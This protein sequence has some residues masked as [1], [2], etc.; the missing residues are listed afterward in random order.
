MTRS[1]TFGF[2]ALF[3][4]A[5]LSSS[6]LVA[7]DPHDAS[8]DDS[9]ND[10]TDGRPSTKGQSPAQSTDPQPAPAPASGAPT[11]AVDHGAPSTIFPAFA[12]RPPQVVNKGGAVAA[13]P[14]L[15]TVTW[16]NDA[17]ADT[18]EALADAIGQSNYWSQIVSQYGV[19]KAT[20]D[21]LDH[22]RM[23][24]PLPTTV[25]TTD[26]EQLIAD[27]ADGDSATWPAGAGVIYTLYLPN[28]T[29]LVDN[30]GTASDY[31]AQGIGGYHSV[32][33]AP[34]GATL[35]YAIVLQ[36][37]GYGLTDA[38][39]SASHEW[40]EAATDPYWNTTPAFTGLRQQDLAWT[41][42]QQNQVEIG[43]MCEFETDQNDATEPG[44]P[45]TVQRQWSN[46]S[47][48]QGH[49]PCV[50]QRGA[51]FNAVPLDAPSDYVTFDDGAGFGARASVGYKLAVGDTMTIAFGIASDAAT[52]ALTLSASEIVSDAT[53]INPWP[54]GKDVT[55]SLDL[56]SGQNGEKTY[57]TIKRN[58]RAASGSHLVVVTST[59]GDGTKRNFPILV[60]DA[61]AANATGDAGAG[62]G[63]ARARPHYFCRARSNCR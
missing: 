22:V 7:C 48:Q 56:T 17:S 32:F 29:K 36:C 12:A 49:S 51:Y 40:V 15:V 14:E 11:P 13:S 23:T 20:S 50:P 58:A 33:T 54:G 5:S 4:L 45:F 41:E 25:L 31:C 53:G 35:L 42:L 44:L 37:P 62:T 43:D 30:A 63:A 10:L 61:D 55:L 57:L 34:S 46:A 39:L 6:S 38:T 21:A 19:G 24:T 16:P 3:S 27:N 52:D 18:F 28:G 8:T 9:S 59:A 26:L 47:A 1:S 60:G 2:I